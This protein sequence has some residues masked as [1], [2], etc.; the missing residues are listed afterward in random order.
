MSLTRLPSWPTSATSRPRLAL[1][2]PNLPPRQHGAA[3]QVYVM[4]QTSGGA[5]STIQLS[6]LGPGRTAVPCR[7]R[8]ILRRADGRGAAASNSTQGLDAPVHA[9]WP[10][11]TWAVAAQPTTKRL[12]ALLSTS[13]MTA[14][15]CPL[16][17]VW[18]TYQMTLRGSV[19]PNGTPVLIQT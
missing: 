8:P 17:T 11:S 12:P 7:L 15:A 5:R 13:K 14:T 4:D 19:R 2:C 1:R 10:S 18:P 3:I 6:E 16:A 9:G